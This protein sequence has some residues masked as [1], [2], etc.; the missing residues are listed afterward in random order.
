MT[1]FANLSNLLHAELQQHSVPPSNSL[2]AL[3]AY[4]IARVMALAIPNARELIT[5]GQLG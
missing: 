1:D 4:L 5:I 2:V 3:L